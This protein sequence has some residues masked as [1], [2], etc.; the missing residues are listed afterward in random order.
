MLFVCAVGAP[1][2]IAPRRAIA[3]TVVEHH[4]IGE[5]PV[6]ES[7][8]LDHHDLH[9]DVPTAPASDQPLEP[10]SSSSRPE[11][12]SCGPDLDAEGDAD[13]LNFFA[14]VEGILPTSFF[15]PEDA[16]PFDSPPFHLHY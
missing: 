8:D 4:S 12:E 10:V 7:G 6:L 15:S 9:H 13:Y 16:N 2:F 3:P 1:G 14:H 11:T 5:Y